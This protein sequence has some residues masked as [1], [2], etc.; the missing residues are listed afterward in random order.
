[1]HMCMS[2]GRR[3]ERERMNMN[4]NMNESQA[5]ATLSVRS[6][7]WGSNSQTVISWPEPKPRVRRCLPDWAPQEP[8]CLIYLSHSWNTPMSHDDHLWLHSIWNVKTVLGIFYTCILVSVIFK[9]IRVVM[10]LFIPR[11]CTFFL[12]DI[13]FIIVYI[14]LLISFS[15]TC[16]WDYIIVPVL[17]PWL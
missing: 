7:I 4:M 8:W 15:H 11:I 14:L 12:L 10:V 9:S 6:P 3:G 5:G 17:P 16:T 1:M 2:V 13:L